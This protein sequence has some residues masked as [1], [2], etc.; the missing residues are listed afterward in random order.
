MK[1]EKLLGYIKITRPFNSLMMGFGV[2]I[3]IQVSNPDW[4][5]FGMNS[6]VG[7]IKEFYLFLLPFLVG[8]FLSSSSMV[9]NDYVDYKIDLIN[10]PSKPIP[11]GVISR[12]SAL[13]FSI[14]LAS[15]G[16]IISFILMNFIS[17]LIAIMG[18]VVA[19]AYN[20]FLKRRGILGNLAVTYTTTLPFIYGSSLMGFS[21]FL[22]TFI[23]CVLAFL[24]NLSR[25]IIKGIVDVAGDLALGIKTIAN[26]K[27]EIFAAKLSFYFI[28]TT[29]L[30][31][32]L[33]FILGY[34]NPYY[35]F[36]IIIANIIFIYYSYNLLKNAN[37]ENA[38]KTKNKFLLAMLLSLIAF[39]L[40]SM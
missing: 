3:G 12:I 30:L 39:F 9:L 5:N 25:E 21:N 34:F 2:I 6:L 16:L 10:F 33:P 31:S 8:F 37:K 35:I 18:L 1:T 26:S 17:I 32:P 23:L 4:L 24:S 27:G 19:I 7:E 13:Y 20:F 15:L 22:P 29:V 38:L 11:S 28:I 40:A 36:V 14:L